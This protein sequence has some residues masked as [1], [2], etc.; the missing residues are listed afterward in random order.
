MPKANQIFV[1]WYVFYLPITKLSFESLTGCNILFI[2]A[3]LTAEPFISK[4]DTGGRASQLECEWVRTFRSYKMWTCVSSCFNYQY[5]FCDNIVVEVQFRKIRKT[6]AS[7]TKSL[8][9]LVLVTQRQLQNVLLVT[10]MTQLKWR[11]T[12]S[13]LSKVSHREKTGDYY[14][15]ITSTGYL[16]TSPGREMVQQTNFPWTGKFLII[17]QTS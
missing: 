5:L 16:A 3:V 6:L 9:H 13:H 10:E 14:T 4:K 1:S 8:K 17:Q 7:V 2:A 15:F 11:F 12:G